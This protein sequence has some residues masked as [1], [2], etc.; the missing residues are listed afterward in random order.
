[1]TVAETAAI[2]LDG[3]KFAVQ[4]SGYSDFSTGVY[5]VVEQGSCTGSS[6]WCYANGVDTDN[7]TITTAL[8]SDAGACVAGIGNGCGT[9]NESG[10]STSSFEHTKSSAREY[11]FTLKQAGASPGVVYFFRLFDVASG[12]AVPLASGASYPSVVTGGTEL[13]VSI[14]GIASSTPIAGITTSVGAN[15]AAATAAP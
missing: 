11:E 12:R 8:L 6:G 14:D 10:V 3:V 2:G 1:M 15:K 13:T 9:H 7:A 5:T 4:Y